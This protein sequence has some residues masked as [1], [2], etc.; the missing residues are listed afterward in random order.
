MIKLTI[1]R[2]LQIRHLN[3]KTSATIHLYCRSDPR[4]TFDTIGKQ[5]TNTVTYF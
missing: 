1:I 5:A 2:A 3:H 4:R